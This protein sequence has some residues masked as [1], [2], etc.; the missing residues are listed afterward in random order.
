MFSSKNE[1]EHDNNEGESEDTEDAVGKLI[2]IALTFPA[3]IV[4]FVYYLLL[5]LGRLRF[6]VIAA[7]IFTV[8]AFSLFVFF[9]SDS[10]GTVASVISDYGAIGSNWTRLLPPV[11]LASLFFGGFVGLGFTWW[12][13]R[14]M[15]KNPYRLQLAGNW[16]YRFEFRRTPFEVLRKKKLVA[17]LKSGELQTVEKTPLGI[18]EKGTYNLV[19]RY[20]SEANKHFLIIGS[21]GSGKTITMQSLILSDIKNKIP[22][23]LIDMKRSPEFASKLASWAKAAGSEFYHFVNGEPNQYDIAN[24]PGQSYYDPLKSGSPTSKADM[25]L[26][27]REYDTAS[28]VYKSNMQQLLQV[29]FAML[30]YADREKAKS[31][32]WNSGGIYQL[33]SA[34]QGSNIVELAQACEGTPI[35][36]EAEAV[37][38]AAQGRTGIKHAM[39]ELQGQM[40]TIV[41]SEYGRWLKLS[42]NKTDDIDIFKTTQKPGTVILF[43]LNSDSE[44]DFARYV[45][46]MIMADLTSVSARRRN[47][48]IT[49]QV[50]V[51]ID[52][53]Q[54]INPSSVA[55]LLEKARESKI[56]M[57]LA[58][59][60]FEQI[61]AST[62]NNGEAYLRS[63]LDTCSNFIVHAG[64]TEDSAERLSKIL[65]KEWFDSYRASNKNK[66]S[67]LSFNW[68]NKRN[69]TVQTSREERWKFPP[70][71]FMTLS[72]PDV[73]NGF[74]STAAVV[75]KT[76][77]DPLYKSNGGAVA[78]TVWMIPPA[79]VLKGY[80]VPG[81]RA[82]ASEVLHEPSGIEV[83]TVTPQS[84]D[85]RPQALTAFDEY[86]EHEDDY[87]DEYLDGGFVIENLDKTTLDS[88]EDDFSSLEA[89]LAEIVKQKDPDPSGSNIKRSAYEESLFSKAIKDSSVVDVGASSKPAADRKA[90]ASKAAVKKTV[91]NS[92][93]GE[94]TLP[95]LPSL[96]TLNGLPRKPPGGLPTRPPE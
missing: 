64:S 65:G 83:D 94:D 74:K 77:S 61:V 28:A 54:T 11:L 62:S 20:I 27:M 9:S 22:V 88:D 58:Q 72:S 86:T 66:S 23:I 45:G 50:N 29:L 70:S 68:K 63:I 84:T 82:Q 51:Y 4:G 5:R 26:G 44:P 85:V 56:A 76:C 91:E 25:V 96:P 79:E 55:G 32:D 78:R 60:S 18:T 12:T 95:S 57:T 92:E 10:I 80:Y 41:A 37:S 30:K 73:N 42:G 34:V 49:N 8:Q 38:I 21:S 3:I 87:D 40:R 13:V 14:E 7:I 71:E 75:N 16:M 52:E 39:D 46:S 53:F 19:S 31:I 93:E 67:F 89:D 24:S 2:L 43:S 48:Q 33:A 90:P 1:E 35:Q 59:Q 36:A 6:S 17:K 15:R 69:Q 81:Q 47:S